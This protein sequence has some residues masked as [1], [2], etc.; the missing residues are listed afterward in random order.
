MRGWVNFEYN[1]LFPSGECLGV[2]YLRQTQFVSRGFCFDLDFYIFSQII[3][4]SFPEGEV[5]RE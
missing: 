3:L 5:I 1:V 4:Q 2:F